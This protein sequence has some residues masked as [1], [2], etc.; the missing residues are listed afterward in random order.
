MTVDIIGKMAG[1]RKRL[2]AVAKADKPSFDERIK[3]LGVSQKELTGSVSLAL[4]V[5]LEHIDDQAREINNARMEFNELE[6]LVDVDCLAPVPNRRAFMRRLEWAISMN[7]RYGQ[8][9]SL[10]FC[11]LNKF[12]E[13]NDTHGHAAGDEVIREVAQV[14]ASSLRASDFLAGF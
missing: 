1:S 14:I 5:L 3:H 2:S 11:D 7:K 12:K 4:S 13:I 6:R 9:C 10:L 8:R